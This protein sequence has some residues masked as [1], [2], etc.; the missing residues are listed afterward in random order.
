VYSLYFGRQADVE[1]KSAW[2]AIAQKNGLVFA[3]SWILSS[4]ESLS[5]AGK[6]VLPG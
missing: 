2:T 5:L 3:L 6:A 1:G 4:E